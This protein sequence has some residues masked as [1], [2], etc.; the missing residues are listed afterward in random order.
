MWALPIN[1]WPSL[2]TISD[3]KV[4]AA[5]NNAI[6]EIANAIWVAGGGRAAQ[7]ATTSDPSRK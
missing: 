7:M 3:F 2:T 4:I 1:N 6:T 5:I